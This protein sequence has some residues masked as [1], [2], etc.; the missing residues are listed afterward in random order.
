MAYDLSRPED[1]AKVAGAAMKR[2]R[3]GLLL[4]GSIQKER[5]VDLPWE[6]VAAVFAE[7]LAVF[8]ETTVEESDW[9]DGWEKARQ[10][11]LAEIESAAWQRP[12]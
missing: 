10:P 2:S 3:E 5:L 4:Q 7:R 6:K 11:F 9:P 12:Q 1:G 8:L